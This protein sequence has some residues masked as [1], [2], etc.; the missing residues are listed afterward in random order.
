M[1]DTVEPRWRRNRS[2]LGSATLEIATWTV[3]AFVAAVTIMGILATLGRHREAYVPVATQAA[4][5]MMR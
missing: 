3:I 5:W 2:D 1:R 4:D